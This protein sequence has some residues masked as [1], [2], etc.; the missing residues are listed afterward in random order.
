MSARITGQVWDLQ[1]TRMERLILLAMADHA[2]HEGCHVFPS[3]ALIAWK[4]GY[5][6]RQVQR[7]QDNLKQRKI[8]IP[9]GS[10][11]RGVLHYRLDF[12]HVP[13]KPPFST[14]D[15]MTIVK[16]SPVKNSNVNESLQMN[17]DKMSIVTDDKMTIDK[18]STVDIYDTFDSSTM[19]I[20][21]RSHNKDARAESLDTLE[22]KETRAHSLQ[23][24]KG[25]QT[26]SQC[27][28][29][30]DYQPSERVV[31]RLRED[32]PG[33]DIPRLVRSMK[34][35]SASKGE[36]RRDWDATLRTF[37]DHETPHITQP[38]SKSGLVE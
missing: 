14:R 25:R 3:Q 38:R 34:N 19:D 31:Q 28:C 13:L 33:A 7:V 2:D 29:P 12:S 20:L 30:E 15:K 21:S 23:V 37:A 35:W 27:L 22:P 10:G 4:T 24:K 26:K 16:M 6:K 9:E 5:S 36:M 18:M 32:Y 11:Y 8:L 17:S 1:L